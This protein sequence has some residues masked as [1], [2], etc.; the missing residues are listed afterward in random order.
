MKRTLSIFVLFISALSTAQ[1]A[2]TY[3][4]GL[5]VGDG[6]TARRDWNRESTTLSWTVDDTTAPGL[7]H[8]EY[9]LSVRKK[10]HDLE[11]RKIQKPWPIFRENLAKKIGVPQDFASFRCLSLK[12]DGPNMAWAKFL[13]YRRLWDN[14]RRRPK[15]ES[16]HRSRRGMNHPFTLRK[17]RASAIL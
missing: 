13:K 2:V 15:T 11:R 5:S 7:W 10:N 9:S 3:S 1:G 12:Q 17:I 16:S 14:A 4:G 6:L 8:Y